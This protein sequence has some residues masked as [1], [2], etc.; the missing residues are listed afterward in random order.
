[1]V[2]VGENRAR[3]R[4]TVCPESRNED[5]NRKV[6]KIEWGGTPRATHPPGA[7]LG[8]GRGGNEVLLAAVGQ[9]LSTAVKGAAY[10]MPVDCLSPVQLKKSYACMSYQLRVDSYRALCCTSLFD[11]RSV[12]DGEVPSPFE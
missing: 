3:N 1:M 9:N 5:K 6:D 2:N 11:F 10:D 12:V 4:V 7:T 8:R